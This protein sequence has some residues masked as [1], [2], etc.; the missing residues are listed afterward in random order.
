MTSGAA[1]QLPYLFNPSIKPHHKLLTTQL[2]SPQLMK[3]TRTVTVIFQVIISKDDTMSASGTSWID[4]N[5]QAKRSAAL[6]EKYLLEWYQDIAEGGIVKTISG[7]K[8]CAVF[9]Q[10]KSI[11]TIMWREGEAICFEEKFDFRQPKPRENFALETQSCTVQ[12]HES[13]GWMKTAESDYLVYAFEEYYGLDVY[14]MDFKKLRKWFWKEDRYKSF[15]RYVMPN[16]INHTEVYLPSRYLVAK[17]MGKRA[18]RFLILSD[19]V[20][21]KIPPCTISTQQYWEDMV[22][23]RQQRKYMYN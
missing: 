6:R 14:L 20:Y 10:K 4:T 15:R 3:I 23:V 18:R 8:G 22:Q 13:D 5:P 1:T 12:G 16:T 9:M 11:D 2:K 17:A 19:G 21:R 7:K